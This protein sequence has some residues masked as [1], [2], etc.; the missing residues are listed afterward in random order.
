[1]VE[2]H[3]APREI[4]GLSDVMARLATEKA[5][6]EARL[7]LVYESPEDVAVAEKAM[8]TVGLSIQH[9]HRHLFGLVASGEPT[10]WQQ[11]LSDTTPSPR[12]VHWDEIMHA[13]P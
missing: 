13:L 9:R 8:Q 2:N 7:I 5:D 11:F 6:Q 1:V 12:S 10:I 4:D 3:E